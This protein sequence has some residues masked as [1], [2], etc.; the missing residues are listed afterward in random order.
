VKAAKD[1]WGKTRDRSGD[2][3]IAEYN[4]LYSQRHPWRTG[5]A[6]KIKAR[7]LLGNAVKRGDVIKQ[8]CKI[9]GI[10]KVHGHHEDYDKPLE[11]VWLCSK[12]HADVHRS[13][14]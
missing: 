4:R 11:V 9:C 14:H 1:K 7:Q 10:T 6:H 3:K 12:H 5:E 8:P 2:P 13:S